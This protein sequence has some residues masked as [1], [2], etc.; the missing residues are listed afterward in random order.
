MVVVQAEEQG[1]GFFRQG[2]DED[3]KQPVDLDLLRRLQEVLR[4]PHG[5]GAHHRDGCQ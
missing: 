2:V 1:F 4:F 5:V 3:G